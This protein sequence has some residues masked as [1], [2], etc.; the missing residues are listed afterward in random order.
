MDVI[1]NVGLDKVAPK[2]QS[3]TNGQRNPAVLARLSAAARAA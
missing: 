3:Y 1:L 2:G